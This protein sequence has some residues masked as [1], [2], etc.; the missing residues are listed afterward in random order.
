MDVTELDRVAGQQLKELNINEKQAAIDIVMGE[1]E[2]IGITMECPYPPGTV[3]KVCYVAI[4]LHAFG[5]Y[6]EQ[7]PP[8]WHPRDSEEQAEPAMLLAV[9]DDDDWG[10][11]AGASSD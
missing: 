9:E 7:K 11:P 3:G 2:R 10:V 5:D 1:L 4:R 6:K 8:L